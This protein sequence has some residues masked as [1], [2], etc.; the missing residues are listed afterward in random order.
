MT[1]LVLTGAP[2]V[3]KTTIVMGVA[4][5][6]KERR[7]SV[8]GI[9]SREIRTNNV[10]TGF[11]FIDLATNG[12]DILAS[13]TGNGPR[14]GKYSVN[15]SGCR[16]A[17]E[18]LINALITS[19]VI[20]CDEIGPM[21]LKS[22]EFVDVVKNLLNTDKKVIVVMHQKL[23]HPLTDEFRK[24]SSSLININLGNRGGLIE[25]LLDRLTA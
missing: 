4:Q 20:I 16:F 18:R 21:E 23:E 24:K 13:I 3:G 10:R 7:M 12:R 17:A 15:L 14:V 1:I 19:E 2:G 6:L 9:V 8:G 11:E 22:K 25:T 5:K